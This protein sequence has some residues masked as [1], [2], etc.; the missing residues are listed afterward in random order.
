MSSVRNYSLVTLAYWGFTLTDGALRMLVLLHFH[1]LGY[2]SIQ[3]AFLF[4]LY[5]FF[6]IVTNLIGGWLGARMGL[7]VT[8]FGGL[9]LQVLALAMLTQLNPAWS[10]IA[11][12]AFVMASQALSG[13]AKDLTKMSAKSAIKSLVPD[14]R[15]SLLF[16]WVALLTGSKNALK[17]LGFFLGGFLLTTLGFNGALWGMAG[18]L[19]VILILS[20]ISLPHD[21]GRAKEK[22][23]FNSILSQTREINVLSAARFFLFGS[24]DAW[25]VVGLPIFLYSVLE[26]NFTQVGAYMAFWVIGYGAVQA[27]SPQLMALGLGG[28]APT[29]RQAMIWAFLLLPIP[30]LIA[31]AIGY[32]VQ[33]EFAVLTGLILFGV[34][35]A[36][37][38]AVHSYLIVAYAQGDRVA[39][40]VGFYYMSNAGGRLIGTLLSGV[41]FQ[42]FG[43][44]G[45]LWT[46]ALLVFASGVVALFLTEQE[47]E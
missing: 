33:P 35:F 34:V 46:S 7:K 19:V 42:W 15:Q 20:V 8:L 31:L 43:L 28:A 10:E 26:W 27:F 41:V 44:A 22:P 30:L 24:R 36:V 47:N 18:G 1:K 39:M 13:I 21:I 37:N 5:E 9:A 16:K 32:D 17:G 25:F 12:V 6:G 40:N 23:L 45:C 29:G 4:L 2:S 38:S 3:L 11:A 14:D